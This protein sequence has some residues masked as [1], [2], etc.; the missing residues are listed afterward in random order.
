MQQARMALTLRAR[1]PYLYLDNYRPLPLLDS[2][3]AT[4][5]VAATT[6]WRAGFLIRRTSGLLRKVPCSRP[7]HRGLGLLWSAATARGACRMRASTM[8]ATGDAQSSNDGTLECVLLS[9]LCG[10]RKST[11]LNSSH[12]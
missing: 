12:L 4:N 9:R 10:D 3:R 2:D 1:Y 7:Y 5:S 11:R 8:R 6:A